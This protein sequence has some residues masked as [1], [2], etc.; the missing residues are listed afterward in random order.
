MKQ[1]VVTIEAVVD[2]DDFTSKQL[3]A[4]HDKCHESPCE[5]HPDGVDDEWL[6]E[7]IALEAR[8]LWHSKVQLMIKDCS[9]LVPYRHEVDGLRGLI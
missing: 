2:L 4:I 8:S 6:A 5:T 3:Q 7:E 9:T 1:Y